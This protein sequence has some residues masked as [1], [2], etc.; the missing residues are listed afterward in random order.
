MPRPRTAGTQSA[1]ELESCVLAIIEQVGSC[2]RYSV[3]KYLAESLSS[4]WSGS[5]GAIY[6]MLQRFT[7]KG[8]VD[9]VEEPFG[10]RKR[11]LYQL[12]P[13][14]RTHLHRW[15]SAPVPIEAAAH[16][17][18]P[19]RARVFFL[20]MVEKEEQLEFL[21]DSI[22]KTAE[23]IEKHRADRDELPSGTSSWEFRGREGALR[24]LEAR[25]E[26]LNEVR[27]SVADETS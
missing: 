21:D 14:G 4:F 16:T 9:V 27:A 8:W 2:T 18:D 23:M 13:L 20:D 24:E 7:A 11:S 22:S 6:P 10:S 19:L 5:A 26:W 15:L 12:T 25:A 3:R 17:Y 1:T